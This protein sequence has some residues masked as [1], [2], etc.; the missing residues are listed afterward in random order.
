MAANLAC[1]DSTIDGHEYVQALRQR[2]AEQPAEELLGLLRQ[3]AESVARH[4]TTQ[5]FAASLGLDKGVTGYVYH[6]VSVSI[7][8]GKL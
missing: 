8:H 1:R 2:L 3:A 6:T 5:A 7:W 4:E